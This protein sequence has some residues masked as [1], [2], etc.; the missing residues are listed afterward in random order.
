MQLDYGFQIT[1]K[2]LQF[3]MSTADEVLFGGAAGGGK[4]WAQLIDAFLFAIKYPKSKQLIMRRTF[5]ELN[6]SLIMKSQE[7]YPQEM[8]SYKVAKSMW[9]FN[10]GSIIEF[11]YCE[12]ESDVTI[13]QSAEYDIIRIDEVTHFTPFQY[14]YLLSRI[15]GV[16]DYPKQMKCTTNPG[17]IGHAFIKK[18]F[19]TGFEPDKIY[20]NEIG[21]THVFIQSKVYDNPFLMKQDPA[22]IKRLKELPEAERKALLDGDWDIFEGQAFTEWRNA[23]DNGRT[24]THVIRPFEIPDSWPRYRSFDFGYAK[25]FS[26]GWWA[27]DQDGRVYRYRELYGCSGEENEGVRLTPKEIAARIKEIENKY[28]QGH[29]VLGIADPAIFKAT[30]GESVSE[31]MEKEGVYFIPGDNTRLAGKMQLHYRLKFDDE[32]Y[33]M[34][35]V[36]D[37]CKDFI[38]TIP[39]LIYSKNDPEDIDTNGEDHAYDDTRYFLMERPLKAIV[40]KPR[41]F[42]I[43]PIDPLFEPKKISNSFLET[44]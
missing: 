4:S 44:R 2:Q 25:P 6:R 16:N 7:I 42:R 24:Y 34:L 17:N 28:E 18:R 35:Y 36:F 41:E 23:P 22:Y 26:V 39:T 1:K 40:K 21:N 13:Y 43:V 9:V 20:E 12:S 5:P 3:I 33:P 37:N 19:I 27:V 14:T 30:D 15:R 11:G 38:R 29:R 8:C 32:G 31:Q 10:N